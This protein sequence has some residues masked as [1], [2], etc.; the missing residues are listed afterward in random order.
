MEHLETLQGKVIKGIFGLPKATPYWGLLYELDILPIKLLLTYRKLM[1]YHNFMNSDDRR[2]VKY[3][4]KEQ[5]KSGHKDCWYGNVRDEGESIGVLVCEN[6]VVG[7]PK[8]K[9]KRMIKGKIKE[10]F[11]KE[12]EE[13]KKISKKLRFLQKK[14]AE[15]YLKSLSNDDARLA[16]IIRL[17]MCNW[18]NSNFGGNGCCPLCGEEL[19]TTEHVFNCE[20]T[21][22]EKQVTVKN[23][24][25]GEKMMDI[26]QLF[27]LAE[28]NRRE[29]MLDE[30]NE[31]FDAM[32]AEKTV[33]D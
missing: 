18:I 17:N 5:E 13:K 4:I 14:G 24:E 23:L 21:H 19:D 22:N 15:T 11:E 12:V 29:W 9:W 30:I 31:N 3:L 2:V 32:R 25:E 20:S 7:K 16:L 26:V 28:K 27:R 10:A 1:L 33:R 6:E 8:S